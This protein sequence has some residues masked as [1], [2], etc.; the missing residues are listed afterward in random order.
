MHFPVANALLSPRHLDQ[1]LV[2]LGLALGDTFLDLRDLDASVLNLA[3]DVGPE[4]DGQL[5]P[6]DLRLAPDRL[7]LAGGV[8][9]ETSPLLLAPA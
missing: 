3:L 6:L 9:D 4:P 8:R 7:R 2:D 1:L 5:A